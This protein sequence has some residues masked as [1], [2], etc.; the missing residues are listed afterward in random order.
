[1]IYKEVTGSDWESCCCDFCGWW[2]LFFRC[3]FRLLS[4]VLCRWACTIVISRVD[5]RGTNASISFPCDDEVAVTLD[6]AQL[7]LDLLCV[8]GSIMP[9]CVQPS[10][11]SHFLCLRRRSPFLL[12]CWCFSPRWEAIWS[13]C[14]SHMDSMMAWEFHTLCRFWQLL[15]CSGFACIIFCVATLLLPNPHH[16]DPVNEKTSIKDTTTFVLYSGLLHSVHSQEIFV[17]CTAFEFYWQHSWI[18]LKFH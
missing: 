5:L 15:F 14:T 2:R 9:L 13:T 7:W 16:F 18:P 4:R 1:M 17:A 11:S 3:K 12:S 8:Y 10:Y 6:I